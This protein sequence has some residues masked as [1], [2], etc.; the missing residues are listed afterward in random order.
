[1]AAH[2]A[3]RRSQGVILQKQN[4]SLLSAPYFSH[5]I[6]FCACWE[7]RQFEKRSILKI[8]ERFFSWRLACSCFFGW[9]GSFLGM[10]KIKK[11]KKSLNDLHHL[12]LPVPWESC[13]WIL[14][15]WQQTSYIM[16]KSQKPNHHLLRGLVEWSHWHWDLG[17]RVAVSWEPWLC[18]FIHAT[19][20]SP[21]SQGTHGMKRTPR[22]VIGNLGSSSATVEVRGGLSAKLETRISSQR[23]A[24]WASWRYC[25][26][27]SLLVWS[28]RRGL[29]I[30]VGSC[31]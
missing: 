5:G 15:P 12:I 3:H 18:F 17:S 23:F 20:F 1:M 22:W 21:P 7:R 29:V 16:G 25:G 19:I 8:S 28:W 9:D 27:G 10:D 24:L 30:D 11:K 26:W 14:P 13:H 6:V 2:T 4:P 31:S